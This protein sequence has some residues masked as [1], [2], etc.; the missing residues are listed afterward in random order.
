MLTEYESTRQIPGE[1]FRRWF[2][3]SDTDL[4]IWSQ[5]D[6]IVGFQL[7]SPVGTEGAV[8]TWKEGRGTTVSG[9]DEGENRPGRHKASPLLTEGA[10]SNLDDVLRHFL[11]ISQGLSPEICEVVVRI[12]SDLP[13]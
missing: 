11:S 6:R 3:D 1:P 8:V 4:V 10:N 9:L 12:I 13:G 2:A 5:G 7:I